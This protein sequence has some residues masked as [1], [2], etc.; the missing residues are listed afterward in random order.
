M[1]DRPFTFSPGLVYHIVRGIVILP[2]PPRTG[3]AGS[4]SRLRVTKDRH[5]KSYV[6]CIVIREREQLWL[7]IVSGVV[8]D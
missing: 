5:P 7:K 1:W 6:G 8:L 3:V 2:M 4:Q